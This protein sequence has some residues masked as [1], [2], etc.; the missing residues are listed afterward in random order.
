PPASTPVADS[1]YAPEVVV[2]ITAAKVVAR[3]SAIIGRSICGRLPSLSRKPARAETP[4]RVPIVST[5]AITRMVRTTGK[6]AQLKRLCKS[7]RKNTGSRLGGK[8]THAVG[9]GETRV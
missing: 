3:A 5:N 8:L 4:I 9:A 1:I 2:P 6:K 7:K